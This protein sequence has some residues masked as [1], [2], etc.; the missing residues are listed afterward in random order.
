MQPGINIFLSFS[1]DHNARPSVEISDLR[2][3]W[4]RLPKYLPHNSS[5]H[6]QSIIIVIADGSGSDDGGSGRG[7]QVGSLWAQFSWRTLS[8]LC[9]GS[10]RNVTLPEAITS[11]SL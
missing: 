3:A 4:S 2:N 1:G 11:S 9:S 8:K 5:K 10:A 7:V 6:S